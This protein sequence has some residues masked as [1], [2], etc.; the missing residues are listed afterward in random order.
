MKR[1]IKYDITEELEKDLSQ[2]PYRTV[3][4]VI[5]EAY[6]KTEE[7]LAPREYGKPYSYREALEI[8]QDRLK[9][10]YDLQKRMDRKL[11]EYNNRYHQEVF[12]G[13]E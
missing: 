8:I 10:A 6:S 12:E 11:K 2:F 13:K 5:R 7:M 3:C 1:D 9:E 4:E